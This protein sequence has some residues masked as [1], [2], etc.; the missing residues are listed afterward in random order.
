MPEPLDNT[1][2]HRSRCVPLVIGTQLEI[3]TLATNGSRIL[4]ATQDMIAKNEEMLQN[5]TSGNRGQ[6]V[7][8]V[9]NINE[10]H[11]STRNALPQSEEE[12][13]TLLQNSHDLSIHS[14]KSVDEDVSEDDS[15]CLA[16]EDADELEEIR[17]K[18]AETGKLTK[19]W[20]IR[21][22]NEERHL[23][24][25]ASNHQNSIWDKICTLQSWRG[26]IWIRFV[27]LFVSILAGITMALWSFSDIVNDEKLVNSHD[28]HV[29]TTRPNSTLMQQL[30]AS[31]RIAD[32]NSL[33]IIPSF[34]EN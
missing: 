5:C 22:R 4:A 20:E 27:A 15:I 23:S 21:R 13:K 6:E 1:F 8:V 26:C 3:D 24:L 17:S 7:V 28:Y 34:G 31:T 14:I 18:L 25:L 19:I 10:I 2:H 32:N 29:A 30:P 11:C 9:E 33:A 12:G 16:K